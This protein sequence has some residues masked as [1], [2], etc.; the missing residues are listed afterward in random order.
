MKHLLLYAL[1]VLLTSCASTPETPEARVARRQA[2]QQK[3]TEHAKTKDPTDGWLKGTLTCLADGTAMPFRIE[4]KMAWGGSATGGVAATHPVT[5]ERFTGQYTGIL[6]SSRGTAQ[7]HTP[8]GR[9]LYGN[10]QET[11]RNANAV[12]TLTGDKGTVIQLEMQILAGWTPHGIGSGA[13]N[14][15]QRYQVQF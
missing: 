1:C 5:S 2:D 15:G 6:P 14:R 4:K 11:G 7:L 10:Y 3:R 12:A 9:W 13:D 8:S